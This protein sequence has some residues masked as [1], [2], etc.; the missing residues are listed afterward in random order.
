MRSRV[1]RLRPA[2]VRRASRALLLVGACAAVLGCEDG[3]SSV[4]LPLGGDAPENSDGEAPAPFVAGDSKTFGD[5]VGDDDVGRA[6]F[7]AEDEETALAQEMVVQPIQ[8]DV[9][10]GGI[11]LWSADGSPV[12]ADQLL[13]PRAE[14]KFCNPGGTYA[15]AFTWGPTNEVV[16]VF[17]EETHLVDS[18]VLTQQYLGAMAGAFT[19]AGGGAVEVVARPRERLLIGGQELDVYASRA[20]AATEPRSWLNP[21]NVTNLYRMVRQTFF[22]SEPPPADFDCVAAQICDVLYT[23]ANE[24]TPQDTILALQDSGIA[25]AFTP[26]GY[27]AQIQIEPV[28]SAPFEN[29]GAIS[30]GAADA[31]QMSFGFQSAFRDT[32]VLALDTP[33]SWASFQA[34]C[35][36]SGD[37][38]AIERATYSVDTSRDA[39]SVQFNGITLDFIRDTTARPLFNDGEPPAP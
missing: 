2:R 8:P 38:R 5:R 23:G 21:V 19:D 39:V 27:A 10:A 25:I 9:S 15:N 36:A 3:P 7:C 13:G 30:F 17:N 32:C 20:Q 37:E 28:R 12:N 26:E 1:S 11:P 18:V 31:T 33:T 35:I 6:K 34:S 22:G 16:V 14:G 4:R 24:D 29:G